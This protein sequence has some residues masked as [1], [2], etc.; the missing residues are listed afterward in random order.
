MLSKHPEVASALDQDLV[1]W[2]TTVNPDGKPQSSAVWFIRDGDCLV[3]YSRLDATRLTNLAGNP[4]VAFNLRGDERGDAIVTL[5]GV[6]AVDASLPTPAG[7]PDYLAK[8]RDE[9]VRLGWTHQQYDNEFS[10][11]LR[12]TVTRI[13]AW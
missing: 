3:V 12:I 5:E 8:Y 13:R 6:A 7:S 4:K 2:F 10:V 1:G 9:I 11:A